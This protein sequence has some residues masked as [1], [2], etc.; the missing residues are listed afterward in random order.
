M[1]VIRARTNFPFSVF[2]LVNFAK[3]FSAS[4]RI[5]SGEK[6]FMSGKQSLIERTSGEASITSPEPRG[7]TGL[8]G[9]PIAFKIRSLT[10]ARLA[11]SS[12]THQFLISPSAICPG[13]NR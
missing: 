11:I 5:E 10:I 6:T 9:K 2:N 13:T 8:F 1:D 7:R 4:V 12:S 3:R